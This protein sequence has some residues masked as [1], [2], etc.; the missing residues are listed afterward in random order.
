MGGYIKLLKDASAQ[1]HGCAVFDSWD[2]CYST[3]TARKGIRYKSQHCD[4]TISTP[5]D[6][7][8]AITNNRDCCD[9]NKDCGN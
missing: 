2:C 8:K 4:T 1:Q 3:A 5:M 6:Q 9:P 7:S